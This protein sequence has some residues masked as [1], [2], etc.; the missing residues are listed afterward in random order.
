[1][2]SSLSAENDESLLAFLDVREREEIKKLRNELIAMLVNDI[3]SPLNLI[4]SAFSEVN[5]RV[6]TNSRATRI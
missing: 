6:D 1:M 2:K 5:L 3:S 4:R